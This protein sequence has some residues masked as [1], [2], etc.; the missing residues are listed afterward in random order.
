MPSLPPP[1]ALR[2][3]LPDGAVLISGPNLRLRVAVLRPGLVVVTARGEVKHAD[4]VSAE[5]ALL[6]ELERELDRA[7][8]LKLF[9]DLRESERMPS[10]SR[11]R[12]SMWARRHEKRALHSHVLVR[13]SLLEMAMSIV[14]MLVGTDR[15]VI[16]IRVAAFLAALQKAA[17]E[18]TELP[19]AP[20]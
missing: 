17:P 18:L 20:D 9:A 8:E 10:T 4:D 15:V 11:E 7:G 12:I 2:Q 14:S 1:P 6:R 13:S 16:H 3:A 5:A 19:R